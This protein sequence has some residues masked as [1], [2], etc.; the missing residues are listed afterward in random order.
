MED[1]Q[2]AFQGFDLLIG[3]LFTNIKVAL[4]TCDACILIW[5]L[6][7]VFFTQ[8]FSWWLRWARYV[9][10]VYYPHAAITFI[11]SRGLET[12]S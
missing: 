5:L 8:T 10:H 12:V 3:S 11:N 1:L 7:C 6:L 2:F 9:S 4:L